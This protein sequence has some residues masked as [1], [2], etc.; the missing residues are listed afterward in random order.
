VSRGQISGTRHDVRTF[1]IN[2]LRANWSV[3]NQ[4]DASYTKSLAI[5][6][7]AG[8]SENIPDLCKLSVHFKVDKSAGH[9]INFRWVD[10][11]ERRW[12]GSTWILRLQ[13][14]QLQQQNCSELG[15]I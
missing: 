5:S 6:L 11:G 14:V 13:S 4:E 10:A 7:L 2:I 3:I 12:Y 9:L 8:Q 15:S 1:A